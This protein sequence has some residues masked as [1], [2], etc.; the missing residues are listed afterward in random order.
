M[1]RD[2]IVDLQ[3]VPKRN[4]RNPATTLFLWAANELQLRRFILN[5]LYLS[6]YHMRLKRNSLKESKM[7]L[8]HQQH[9]LQEGPE[10]DDFFLLVRSLDRLDKRI[11]QLD[12]HLLLFSGDSN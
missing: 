7:T 4:D 6:L 10:A 11:N 5:Q 3:E 9:L 12:E 2:H 1:Y 8:I